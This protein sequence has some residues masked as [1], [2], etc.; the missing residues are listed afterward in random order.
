MTSGFLSLFFLKN[1]NFNSNSIQEINLITDSNLSKN[2]LI[3]ALKT[4]YKKFDKKTNKYDQYKAK[5]KL[6][7]VNRIYEIFDQRIMQRLDKQK[8][9]FII[10]SAGFDAHTADPLAN[11]NLVEKDF[12][13][14]TKKLKSLANQYCG[15]K[16]VSM[17]EGGYDIHALEQSMLTHLK[18]LQNND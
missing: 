5:A 15:G 1:K 13:I 3:L 4:N 12:E 2:F 17:L 16:I 6:N 9:D 10:L 14:I 7:L 11:L 18:A 8:P